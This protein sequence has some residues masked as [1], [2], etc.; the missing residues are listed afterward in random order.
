MSINFS[1][2]LEEVPVVTN[3]SV[4]PGDAG[5]GSLRPRTINE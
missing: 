4:L 1:E 2:G 5:E 3:S